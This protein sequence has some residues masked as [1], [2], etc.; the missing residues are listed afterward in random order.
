M[1]RGKMRSISEGNYIGSVPPYGYDKV[2]VM[3]GK[4]KCPTLAPNKEEA[5]I[6]QLIF[7]MYTNQNMGMPNICKHLDSIGAKPPKGDYWSNRALKDMLTNVHYLGKV[8]WNWRKVVTIVEDSE[9]KKTRPKSEIG[10]FL[11]Y[12]GRHEAIITEALFNA[13]QEKLGKNVKL[14]QNMSISLAAVCLLVCAESHRP[15]ALTVNKTCEW[16]SDAHIL[17]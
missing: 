14:R 16:I 8:K 3:D 5:P 9:I 4:R 7:D 15:S 13:A 2:W 17:S 12:E 11:V 6:V 10:E 1:N